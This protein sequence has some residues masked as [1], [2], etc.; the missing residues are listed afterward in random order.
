METAAPISVAQ[1]KINLSPWQLFWQRLRR[2]KIAMFGGVVLIFLYLVSIFAG[3]ISPYDYQTQDRDRFFH[4]PIWPAFHH[5]QLAVPRYQQMP[6]DFVYQ[7]I[8]DDT[9][10]LHF[11][12]R[13]CQYKL[14]GLIPAS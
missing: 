2:R 8:P 12:T 9:A 11:L 10:P 3:F 5:F 6:G 1:V 14:F 7:K 13:G 4:P